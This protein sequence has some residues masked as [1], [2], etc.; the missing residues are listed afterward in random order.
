MDKETNLLAVC[1]YCTA[2]KSRKALLDPHRY[3]DY[4]FA[5]DSFTM[6][7]AHRGDV[8]DTAYSQATELPNIGSVAELI[9]PQKPNVG[10]WLNV[11]EIRAVLASIPKERVPVFD[12]QCSHCG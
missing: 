8:P 3:G 2:E 12:R 11:A 10:K 5:S 4:L 7:I 1:A 6:A 9:E